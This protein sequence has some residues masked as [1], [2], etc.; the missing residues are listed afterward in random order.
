MLLRLYS[1]FLW[2]SLKVAHSHVR[3]NAAFLL[4]DTFPL[5]DPDATREQTNDVLQKQF[6]AMMVGLGGI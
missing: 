6:D 3:A 1:P 2:H 5:Q 4:L